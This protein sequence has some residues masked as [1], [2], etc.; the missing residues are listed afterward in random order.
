M[1]KRESERG[2]SRAQPNQRL[3]KGHFDS[4]GRS[5]GKSTGPVRPTHDAYQGPRSE[6]ESTPAKPAN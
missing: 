5:E 3:P 6:G 4:D 1:P 2:E